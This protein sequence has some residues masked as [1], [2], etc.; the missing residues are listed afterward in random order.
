[1]T[2]W[3]REVRYRLRASKQ[4]VDKKGRFLPLALCIH[5]YMIPGRS[6]RKAGLLSD[7]SKTWTFESVLVSVA[8]V[9]ASEPARASLTCPATSDMSIVQMQVVAAHCSLASGTYLLVA[10]RRTYCTVFCYSAVASTNAYVNFRDCF[11][12][13]SAYAPARACGLCQEALKPL[14]SKP[15]ASD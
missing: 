8:F 5:I 15:S 4:G 10:R 13:S 6:H 3:K 14:G 12:D 2:S 7:P 9:S 1:M 11:S